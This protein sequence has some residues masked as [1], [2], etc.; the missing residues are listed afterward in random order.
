MDRQKPWGRKSQVFAV[1]SA[2]CVAM[3][4]ERIGVGPDSS[5]CDTR[6]VQKKG[7]VCSGES[8]KTPL[9]K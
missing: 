3:P 4:V 2:R 5:G 6:R 1:S 9:K 8:R 7:F